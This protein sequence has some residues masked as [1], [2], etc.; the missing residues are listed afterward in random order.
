MI[1]IKDKRLKISFGKA[2]MMDYSIQFYSIPILYVV[3]FYF[4]VN[5]IAPMYLVI[6][7]FIGIPLMDEFLE[8]D[9]RNP[10]K[11]EERRLES[12]L[13]FKFPLYLS[14][15]IDWFMTFFVI[16]HLINNEYSILN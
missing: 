12:D 4:L 15:F 7:I 8:H 10:T 6:M 14:V 1:T 16:K 5:G 3:L 9:V 2:N 11:E 13:R